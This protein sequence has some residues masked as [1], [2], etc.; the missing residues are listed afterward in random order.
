VVQATAP[1]RTTFSRE[2]RIDQPGDVTVE[3]PVLAPRAEEPLV[4]APAPGRAPDARRGSGLRTAGL[5]VGGVGVVG[6]AAGV[7]F[8]LRTKSLSDGLSDTYDLNNLSSAEDANRFMY[9]SYAVGGA[10]LVTGGILYFL[11][12][13]AGRELPK[14]VAVTRTGVAFT[15]EY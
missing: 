9:L 2:L 8:G 7:L 4:A 14:S 15:W 12:L 1:G 6:I 10:A 3:I 13:R 5:I 11:G